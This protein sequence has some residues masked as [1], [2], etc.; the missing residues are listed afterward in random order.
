MIPT[1]PAPRSLLALA[2]AAALAACGG[3]SSSGGTSSKAATVRGEVKAVAGGLQVAGVTFSTAGAT[4]SVPDDSAT[5]ITLSDESEIARHLA[6]G[7][8]VTVKGRVSD[9]GT[10]GEAA[11]IEFRDLMEGTIDDRGPGRLR[12]LGRTVSVDDSTQ[13]LDDRGGRLGLDDL[14]SGRRVEISGHG[15]SRGGV[16]ATFVRVRDD[17]AGQAEREV[18]GWIVQIAGPVISLSFE[19]GGPIAFSADLSGITPA[20]SVAVGDFVEVKT[21]GPA[22][23]NGVFA[24]VRLEHED[25]LQPGLREEFEVEGIVTAGTAAAFTVAGRDVVTSATT[26]FVGGTPDDLVPGV[27]VEAEGTLDDAGVL[28]ARKVQFK[29]SARIEANVEAIDAAAGTL[30]VLGRVVRVNPSTELRGIS[31]LDGLGLLQRV[32]VRGYPTA[33]GEGLNATRLELESTAPWDRATLRGVVTAKT[34]VTGLTILGLAIDTSAA[35]FHDF[36][37]DSGVDGP[38]MSAQAFFDAITTGTTIVKVRWRPYPDSTAQ[39]VDEAELEN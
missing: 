7:M 13:I 2:A 1:L 8:V 6:R 10:R 21:L 11:E 33:D 24:A 26:R 19:Q 18:K 17:N 38:P 29:P 30:T 4:L 35:S 15:D 14:S 27:K 3:S 20:P 5:R 32:E 22:D 25:D 28:Q 16:S 31:G 37:A 9:D 12:V 23:A 39:A 36:S 34:P